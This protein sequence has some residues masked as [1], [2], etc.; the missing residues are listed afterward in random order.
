MNSILKNILH[1]IDDAFLSAYLTLAKERSAIRGLVFHTVFENNEELER[2]EILPQQR[3]QIRDYK[4]IFCYFLK[5]DYDFLSF[6]DLQTE[7]DPEKN[8]VYLTL[9]DG[10]FN[11]TRLL[12]ILEELNIPVHIFVTTKNIE[13]NKKFWWDVVYENRT[14]QGWPLRRVKK[15]I[16]KLKSKQV[17][18]IDE[19]ILGEFGSG[20]C[21]P[22]SDLDRP[23]SPKELTLLGNHNLVTV[24]NHTHTHSIATRVTKEEFRAE[25]LQSTKILRAS[26]IAEVKGFAFPNGEY[27]QDHFDI[28]EKSGFWQGFSAEERLVYVGEQFLAEAKY[29]LGRFSLSATM[30]LEYQCKIVRAG[31]SPL[32][33]VKKSRIVQAVVG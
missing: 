26:E 6:E 25:I 2:G 29:R 21:S 19:F 20:S 11:N 16:N 8:Y 13:E 14:R 18:A 4:K 32:A 12:P 28:L 5:N 9:D 3:L 7:L 33:R 10:Y 1:Q 15:E 31:G 27:S 22:K 24:G 17:D 23:L 30:G